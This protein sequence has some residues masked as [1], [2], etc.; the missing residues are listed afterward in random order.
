MN[1]AGHVQGTEIVVGAF[2]PVADD[3]EY[4]IVSSSAPKIFVTIVH[5]TIL[6]SHVYNMAESRDPPS[7]V[8]KKYTRQIP[9]GN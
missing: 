4:S 7:K 3:N 8:W 2:P 9:D 1:R 6:I 5:T